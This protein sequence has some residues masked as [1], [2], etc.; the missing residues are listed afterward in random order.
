M[1]LSV[2]GKHFCMFP[3]HGSQRIIEESWTKW[4]KVPMLYEMDADSRGAVGMLLRAWEPAAR[5]CTV[6]LS[7]LLMKLC[8]DAVDFTKLM[9]IHSCLCWVLTKTTLFLSRQLPESETSLELWAPGDSPNEEVWPECVEGCHS[10]CGP[11]RTSGNCTEAT[12]CGGTASLQGY[13]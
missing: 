6:W 5:S 11:C 12:E 1:A 10:G 4:P 9:V 8:E 13:L 7:W 2:S 3:P